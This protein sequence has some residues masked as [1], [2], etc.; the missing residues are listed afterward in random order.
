MAHTGTVLRVSA[1]VARAS[2]K[3]SNPATSSSVACKPPSGPARP[4][5]LRGR[6]AARS[7]FFR[8]SEYSESDFQP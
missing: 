7:M 4:R 6:Y 1:Q 2:G 5:P 8:R 3:T